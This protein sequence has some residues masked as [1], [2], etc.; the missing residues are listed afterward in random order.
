MKSPTQS[1]VPPPPPPRG[2]LA[3]L[4]RFFLEQKLVTFVLLAG[5]VLWGVAVA[6]FDWDLGR[7][8]RAPVP[9]DAIPNLG[10]NQQIVFTEWPGRSPQDV[11]DQV[12]YPLTVSLMGVPGVRE[13]RS[14][15]MFGASLVFL[16]F[17]DDVEFYWARA[18]IVEKLASLPAGLLP[19]EAQPALGP[20][21]TALGQVFWYTLE[22]RDPDGNT[23]GG[24]DLHELRSIQDWT[25][26]YALLSA[27]GIS[28]VASIGGF[29]REYQVDVDPD[30]LRAH[31][32]TLGQ[33][34]ESVR[35]SNLDIGARVTEINRVEYI[36]RGL[37]FLRGLPD[38]EQAVVRAGPDRLP[39]RVADVAAVTLGPAQRR[40][41]LTVM[42]A[43]AV[44][45][46]VVVREGFNPLEAIRNVQARIEEIRTGL[47]ARA[48]V[49]WEATDR[50]AVAAF[51]AEQGFEPFDGAALHQEHWLRWL[52]A[53]PRD[54]WPDGV[55]VSQL[56]IVS[57]YDRTGL[58]HE[59][60]ATLN[61]AL[62]E[63]AL[64]VIAVILILV[65]HLSSALIV[66][67]LLPL[68]ILAAF[69][70]MKLAGVDS[71]LVSLGGIAIAIG[72]IA[73]MGIILSEN[74]R[75]HL[76][77]AGPDAPRLP[78][79]LRGAH[80]VGSAMLTAMTTT[81]LGFLPVLTMT[82]EEGRMFRPMATT[83][84]FVL[85]SSILVAL[86]FVP[87][88]MHA[89]AWRPGAR[90]R[91]I[92]WILLALAAGALAARR[93][94]P[95]WAGLGGAAVLVAAGL[96]LPR[97]IPASWRRFGR[98][99]ARPLA[100]AGNAIAI[101]LAILL[102]ARIWEPLGPARGGLRNLVFVA[103][104]VGGLMA[105]FF[106]LLRVYRRLLGWA[107]AHKAVFAVL[108]VAVVIS[109][110]T[111]GFG[112]DRVF[113][114]F[115]DA[116]EGAGLDARP[117][118]ASRPWVWAV[119]AFPGLGR[120]F[121]PRL[122]EGS[123]LWM[124]TTMPHASL[125][126][127]LEVMQYQDLAMASVPEVD[128]VVG[129]LGRAESALDPAPVSMIETVIHYKPEYVL[130]EAG[131]RVRFRY[132]R[133]AGAFAR[134]ADGELIPDPRGRPYRQWRDHIRTPD[135][136]WNEI[137]RAAE[138]PGTTSAPKLQPIE[139]RLVMLQTGMR[140]PMGMKLRAPDLET[141]DR[142]ALVLE[143]RL[144]EAPGVRAETVNAERVVGKPYLEISV[145][146][147]AAGRYGL[148][149][150]DVQQTIGAALGGMTVTTTVEGRERYPVRV[151]YPRELRDDVT[152]IERVLV[153]A[154]DGAQV[155]LGDVAEV[156]IARG[157]QMIRSEDTFLTAYLTFGGQPGLAEVDV[158]E[159][160]EAYLAAL[161]EAGDLTVPP[162]VSWRFAGA[163]E[164]QLRAMATLRVVLPIALALIFLVLH[165]QFRRFSWTLA[166]FSGIA[167]AWAGGFVMLHLYGRPWFLNF[168][169]F[170]VN[171]RELFNF[172]TVNLSVAV[173]VGF[174]ALFG[175]AV[176]DGV[177]L[178]TYIRQRLAA[179]R[180]RTRAAVRAAVIEA[181][182]RRIRPCVM[183]S[184]TTLLALMPVLASTGRG[185][186][187]L[188]PLAL[189]IVGG[190]TLAVLSW[191]TVPVL[192]AA[193]EEHALSRREGQGLK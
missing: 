101:F 23:T 87:A 131:R 102:L 2:P 32:V 108:P 52:R 22:G 78:T 47:P 30:A 159:G 128:L 123:F 164:H 100:R 95:L 114:P 119:H 179:D 39:I 84:T 180:P 31:G 28:E 94:A 75:R 116:L 134:D 82:G 132:D 145:D 153:A 136:I 163:Y 154:A 46:V 174:L 16:I 42:G 125:G 14:S 66:S 184:A 65:M 142:M 5:L 156:R 90:A 135:D 105:L 139:T 17:H 76:R 188:R 24:W 141:L 6:P 177:V 1:E 48:I 166:I 56:E 171:L 140:A 43:E 130:D 25:V 129:K 192:I 98:A 33:V 150:A 144:R 55:T 45:G 4:I 54:Q 49:D 167:V 191:F 50:A 124:P 162:G 71:N 64:V 103:L 118:R 13:V 160:A 88:L 69:I 34:V 10:E 120:E 181:G 96:G 107:L 77:E 127:V 147:A 86:A 176:D 104:L 175:I 83:W 93:G 7:F 72:V 51:A 80:E 61:D 11:E 165:F 36:V 89:A 38:L 85:F 18:R 187:L 146:R 183:T 81:V 63:E 59:T 91:R 113:G 67:G 92:G 12:T 161:V 189:P 57:F 170:G 186:E 157:P 117:L 133:A 8:P 74:V 79:I 126:E 58:I 9:V 158:V 68:A 44:G 111:V 110:L 115:P 73:D 148:N 40:G 169:V 178:A 37:G 3:A 41:A 149:V 60:L 182:R 137:V 15:S 109:G 53:H 29:V 97:L 26:R 19:D 168:A 27:E 122:D 20:D 21:A 138:I 155:P 70:L 151:R 62:V 193:I 121:M 106:L 152:A 190:M 172:Q 99:V 173:W 35:R 112:F 143:R 185:A